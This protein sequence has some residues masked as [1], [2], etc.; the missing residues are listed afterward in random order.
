M[1]LNEKSWKTNQFISL[2]PRTYALFHVGFLSLPSETHQWRRLYRNQSTTT[3]TTS[4]SRHHPP[5]SQTPNRPTN[6]TI[7]IRT[8]GSPGWN[9]DNNNNIDESSSSSFISDTESA[10]EPNDSV[11]NH[12]F[13]G[14]DG[15]IYERP[16]DNGLDSGEP[17]DNT[18][19]LLSARTVEEETL[20]SRDLGR[21][22]REDKMAICVVSTVEPEI[23]TYS[24]YLF[25]NRINRKAYGDKTEDWKHIPPLHF[26]L[27]W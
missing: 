7:P 21:K 23:P 6:P 16:L 1:S 3:T 4:A 5:P 13:S 8:I 20:L 19:C 15:V 10:H 12:R 18:V 24:T 11:P 2:Y 26:S 17:L 9:K 25:W 27:R 22:R 14:D